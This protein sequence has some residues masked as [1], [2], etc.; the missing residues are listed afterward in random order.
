MRPQFFRGLP[1]ARF[2]ELTAAEAGAL[3]DIKRLGRGLATLDWN[4]DG[5]LDFVATCLDGPVT[6]GTNKTTGAGYGLRLKLVGTASSRDA[7]GARVRIV[8]TG[9]RERQSQLVAGDGYESSNE[10][11][12]EFGLADEARVSRVLIEWPAG[13]TSVF[14]D[15][16]GRGTWLAIEGSRR[17][18]QLGGESP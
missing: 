18:T 13:G 14:D 16:E 3:F 10:R 17:L 7:I 15:V 11:V 2:A 5:L 8:L 6:L 1:G 4:H 12:V 9:G